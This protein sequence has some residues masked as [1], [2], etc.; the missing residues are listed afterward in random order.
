MTASALQQLS[1]NDARKLALISQGVPCTAKAGQAI[2]VTRRIIRHLGY[3]QID[4][5]SVI[6]RAHHHTL[7]NRHPRYR[8]GHLSQL[9]AR[10]RI[11]EYWAH[12]AA[13]LPMEAYRFALPRMWAE[14]QGTGRWHTKDAKLMRR[15]LARIRDEGPLRSRDFADPP[16]D[17]RAMWDW[18]PSKY[19]LEQL[20]MEGQIMA[21]RRE[22]FNKVYDLTERVLPSD[23]DT[24]T[25]ST[26]EFARFLIES[27]LRAHGL[28]RVTDFVHLRQ[29][30]RA[31][32]QGVVDEMCRT[33]ELLQL[34]VRGNLG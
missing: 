12:A 13:Y 10:G 34:R 26:S 5:I 6:E 23:V 4:T 9:V 19:A 15:I 8:T 3:V 18:K 14:R 29:G 7:W 20:F 30:M 2:E 32:V 17:K 16:S 21:V 22:G 1:I 27:F 24:S 33:G 25:P 28:G 31:P 11:F